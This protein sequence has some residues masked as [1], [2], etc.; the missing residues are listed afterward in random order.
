MDKRYSKEEIN[1][2]ISDRLKPKKPILQRLRGLGRR[3]PRIK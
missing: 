3:M 1:K 2:R